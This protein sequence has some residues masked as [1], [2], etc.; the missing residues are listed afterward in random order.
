MTEEQREQVLD[1]EPEKLSG[2]REATREKQG[3]QSLALVSLTALGIV[4]G[5]IGTNCLFALR[6]CFGGQHPI[7]P[8]P[9][10]VLGV[11]SLILWTLLIIISVKYIMYVMR[12]DNRGEGGIL[13]LMALL[14]SW[15]ARDYSLLISLG[16][17]GAALLYGDSMITSAISVL[18][19]IEGLKVATSAFDPYVVP[20]TVVVL[21]L[22]FVFQRRGTAGIGSVFG[23]VML[24]WFCTLAV[25]GILGI[26][27]QPQVMA[28]ASPDHAV[29]F[30]ANNHFRGFLV[31]G[32]VFLV[33]AGGEA[34]YAD[35]GHFSA[36]PV[37]LAWYALVLPAL[38][39][40]Y[41]GQ[42]ALLIGDPGQLTHPFYQLAPGWAVYPL[43]LLATVATVIASQAVISGVFSLSR[44]AAFLGLFP[45]LHVVQTSAIKIGQI[46]VP[47]MN[48]LLMVGTIALV[49]GFRTSSGLAG[50]YG[51]AVSTTMVI[52]TV[53]AFNVTRELWGW[54]MFPAIVVTAGFL[55]V[56]L[57][58]LGANIFRIVQGGWVAL[59]VGT[60][61]FVLMSTWKSGRDIVRRRLDRKVMPVDSFVRRITDDQPVRVPG[62]AVFLSG[63]PQG[64]PPILLHHLKHNQVLHEKVILLTVVIEDVPRVW[65]SDRLEMSEFGMG[66]YQVIVHFG[67]MDD[68]KVPEELSRTQKQGLEIDVDAVTYYVGGQN[69]IPSENDP[70]M[71]VWREKLF[72]YLARNAAW[73]TSF[74][75]LPPDRVIELGM[76]IEL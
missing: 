21:I 33:V 72:V 43:V 37:R 39:L 54:R 10:N 55:L 7:E 30:F 45:R 23:P 73:P 47:T 49:L 15:R 31:L 35:M 57:T 8:T 59:L 11:L 60:L 61:V 50:A 18:S 4:F 27:S 14:Q 26:L 52:T 48:W 1:E 74:Y 6:E 17:F 9:D 24:V 75:G 19:A 36:K 58:F 64:T 76:Q 41:F 53:L 71:A 40:N 46:Y 44:Q 12:M 34:L 69:V 62:T 29:R 28:A 2:E 70:V 20:I 38:L 3:D 25:L 32:A 56:D 42:G 22:L 13:A 16:I 68:P 63:N 5:D 67:F 51:V 65:V 66:I